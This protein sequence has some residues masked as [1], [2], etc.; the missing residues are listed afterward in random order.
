MN[1]AV[2][3][4]GRVGLV[5][6]AAL[7][8][9]GHHVTGVEIAPDRVAALER[10]QMPF[11]EPGLH[12]LAHKNQRAGRLSFTTELTRAARH[13]AAIF[14]TVGTEE[15]ATG[16]PNL[17]P[18]FAVCEQIVRCTRDYK[19]LL[20]K[21]TVPVGTAARLRAHLSGMAL[22]EFDIVS[23]PEFL[24]EGSAIENFLRPDRVILGGASERALAL[25]REIYRPLYLLETPFV[26]VD[27]ESAELIKY[28]TNAF[29]AMKITFINEMA[30][31]CDAAGADV[32][33]IAKAVGL[34][35]RIG[36]KFLH[37]GPGFGGSCLPKDTR[38]LGEMA[39]Q[40]GCNLPLVESVP[41][42]N[43]GIVP[44]LITRLEE[45]LGALRGKTVC[46]LG[47]AY[48]TETDDV[49]ESPALEFVR[50]ALAA[51]A[52]IRAHDPSANAEAAKALA[53]ED[54]TFH[55]SPF[56]AAEG[57]DAV[58]V[59]TEWNEFRSLDL[60]ELRQ[61]MRGS[62][63]LDARN[64][65]DPNEARRQGFDYLGRGRGTAT[66]SN[67]VASALD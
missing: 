16:E 3:G 13:A 48:K 57:A 43:S 52:H 28:A 2:V 20:I 53:G 12:E 29:L 41:V 45:R 37:P 8:D 62:V 66:S 17:A 14:I 27:H 31:L 19:V 7:A 9:L 24:R 34:D 46:V 25:A 63:L 40:L 44:Q 30:T 1:L 36:S 61:Q 26:V 21:S 4:M 54:V 59:L 6:A 11:Y 5:V 58:A 65:Y 67:L 32:H 49:R 60:A 47:L 64:L 33:A 42:S 22:G 23:N 35:K 38:T 15:S 10:G 39:R 51:G 18:F 56:A 55:E 50:L